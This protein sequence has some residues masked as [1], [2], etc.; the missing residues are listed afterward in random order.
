MSDA[1]YM[2]TQLDRFDGFEEYENSLPTVC[3]VSHRAA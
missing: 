3:S 2:G 1:D